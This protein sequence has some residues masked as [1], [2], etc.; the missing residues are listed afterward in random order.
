MVK[1]NDH[2]YTRFNLSMSNKTMTT[3]NFCRMIS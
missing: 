3:Q 1:V 2:F